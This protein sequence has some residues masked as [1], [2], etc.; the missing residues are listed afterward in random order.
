MS[1]LGTL[2]HTQ[3]LKGYDDGVK[4]SELLGLGAFFHRP[5]F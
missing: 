4:H 1:P 3:I 2:T 5:V